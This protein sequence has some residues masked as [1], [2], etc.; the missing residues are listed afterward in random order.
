MA[1]SEVHGVVIKGICSVLPASRVKN[2]EDSDQAADDLAKILH[3]T[4]IYARRV[5]QSG[6]TC[7]DLAKVGASSLL[8][9]LKWQ[10]ALPELLVFV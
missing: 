7:L 4:G 5:V 10:D 1:L 2:Q 3:S 9:E 8:S 6:Q